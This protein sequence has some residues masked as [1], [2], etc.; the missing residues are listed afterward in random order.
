MKEEIAILKQYSLKERVLLILISCFDRTI[1][2]NREAI[3]ELKSLLQMLRGSD[4]AVRRCGRKNV[5][6]FS[7]DPDIGDFQVIV[8]RNTSDVPVLRD[9]LVKKEFKPLVELI[10]RQKEDKSIRTVIDAGANI[11]CSTIF[12]KRAFPDA[13]IISIEPEASNFELLLSNIEVNKLTDVIALQRG[14]WVDD[15]ELVI[16]RDFRDGRHWSFAVRLASPAEAQTIKGVTVGELMSE[17]HWSS[18]DIL[19]VDVEGAE[20]FIFE[21]EARVKSFLPLARYLVME[22]HGETNCRERILGLLSQFGFDH[23]HAGGLTIAVNKQFGQ[24]I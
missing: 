11:G 16:D 6:T 2:R 23:F 12:F 24:R 7:N 19:K 9:I 20:Q 22:I 18:I 13:T 14:L 1:G 8:R 3:C 10:R 4:Y 5:F 17:R 21:S 15:S